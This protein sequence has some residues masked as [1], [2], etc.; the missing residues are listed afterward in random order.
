MLKCF[1]LHNVLR[2]LCLLIKRITPKPFVTSTVVLDQ[3]TGEIIEETFNMFDFKH[4]S[5]QKDEPKT[6]LFV[7]TIEGGGTIVLDLFQREGA[8]LRLA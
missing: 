6:V 3:V 7:V 5:S 1:T 8:Q 4:L 2:G